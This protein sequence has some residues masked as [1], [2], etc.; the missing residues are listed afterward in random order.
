VAIVAPCPCLRRIGKALPGL[1]QGGRVTISSSRLS[2][3]CSVSNL[4][5]LLAEESAGVLPIETKTEAMGFAPDMIG[6]M[7]VMG[8]APAMISFREEET[9]EVVDEG[10]GI[11]GGVG[12]GRNASRG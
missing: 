9:A 4:T 3:P 12:I 11:E 8:F 2:S 1:L 10:C 6:F 5:L 7:E